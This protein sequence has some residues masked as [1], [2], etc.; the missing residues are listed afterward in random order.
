LIPIGGGGIKLLHSMTSNAPTSKVSRGERLLQKF[1]DEGKLSE[2][3]KD[4][5]VT[6]LDPF[7]DHQLKSLTGYPDVQTGASVVRCIKQS[8]S[9]SAP[10]TVTGNWDCHIVQWPWLAPSQVSSGGTGLYAAAANRLGQV[11]QQPIGTP[12]FFSK[13]GGLMI[14]LTPPGANLQILQSGGTQLIGT[15]QIDPVFTQGVTRLLGAGFEVHNTTSQLNVQGSVIGYRQM[16]SENDP[17]AWVILSGDG[18]TGTE[19]SGP[20]VRYPPQNSQDAIL[21]A[22]S[23]Q[24]EAKDGIYSV[25][26]FH[27]LENPATLI[28]PQAPLITSPDTN[29]LEGSVSTSGLYYPI[30]SPTLGTTSTQ[31]TMSFRVHNIHMNGCIFQGLSNSTTLTINWNVFLET[32]PSNDDAEILPLATPSASFDPLVLDIYSRVLTDLP[33]AVPVKENGLGDWFYDAVQTAA[34][35]IGPVLTGLPHPLAKAAGMIATS[36]ANAPAGAGSNTAPPNSWGAPPRA[37]KPRPVKVNAAPMRAGTTKKKKKQ[38][39]KTINITP[40]QFERM[41]QQLKR[42]K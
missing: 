19:F 6:S 14:Y 17:T 30:P 5:L 11:L 7:H 15:L 34:K 40:A 35:Y 8:I 9:V 13:V 12:A 24:W 18:T 2:S 10:S 39:A 32:F 28:K 22:G 3:G 33:V 29:D 4:W 16:A 21:L 26:S 37:S 1:A 36:I 27:N 42:L 41:S 38:K 20:L 31:A 25:S 23:R